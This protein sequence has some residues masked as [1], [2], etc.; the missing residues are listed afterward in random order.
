MF[1]VGGLTIIDARGQLANGNRWRTLSKFGESA[2]YYDMDEATA[3]ILDQFLDSVCLKI[4]S[5]Q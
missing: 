2:S 4:A 5:P 3:K 1:D